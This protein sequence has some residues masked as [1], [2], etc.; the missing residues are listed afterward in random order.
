MPLSARE[1]DLI[2]SKFGFETK[3]GSHLFAWLT[4][5]GRVAVRTRR[6]WKGSGDLPMAHSI[7]QQLKLNSTQLRDAIGCTMRRVDYIQMLRDKQ[8]I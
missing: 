6:S 2:V 8:I 3:T 5:N 1:F 7:R 4:L